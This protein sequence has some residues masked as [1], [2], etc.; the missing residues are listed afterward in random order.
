MVTYVDICLEN[1]LWVIQNAFEPPLFFKS[2]HVNPFVFAASD[3]L[4]D[5]SDGIRVVR[6]PCIPLCFS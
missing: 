1:L 2:N 5:P 6:M 4:N 3:V